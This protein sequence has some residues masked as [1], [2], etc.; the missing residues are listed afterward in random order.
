VDNPE[1]AHPIQEGA[2]RWIM[3]LEVVNTS[4]V[5]VS[6]GDLQNPMRIVDSDGFEFE[7]HSDSHLGLWS[8]FAETSSLNNF[9]GKSLMPK[10]KVRGA[11]LFDLPDED[12]EYS[13]TFKNGT[14]EEI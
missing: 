12:T 8:K 6:C 4:K 1:K 10:I 9:Y 13:L 2:V 5:Y 14:M 11:I 3:G 7:C